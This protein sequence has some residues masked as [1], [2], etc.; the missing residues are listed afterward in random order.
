MGVN[1][2]YLPFIKLR[3]L[4]ALVVA[5]PMLLITVW[6]TLTIRAG[7]EVVALIAAAGFI[8]CFVIDG[9][10]L[11]SDLTDRVRVMRLL[12]TQAVCVVIASAV[13]IYYYAMATRF[14]CLSG[15]SDVRFAQV[16]SDSAVLTVILS[17]VAAAVFLLP[18]MSVLR[19]RH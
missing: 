19:K 14:T 16:Q 18:S 17:I 5:V 4:T 3:R 13:I 15:C 2:N 12:I 9:K 11:R 8:A 1:K 7:F 6:A 10:L